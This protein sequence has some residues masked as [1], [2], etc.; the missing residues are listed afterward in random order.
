MS[1]GLKAMW[2]SSFAPG[3]L[4]LE[5]NQQQPETE[6]IPHLLQSCAYY[7]AY[8]LHLAND[9]HRFLSLAETSKQR[10]S[11]DLPSGRRP[12]QQAAETLA[13]EPRP[14]E[15]IPPLTTITPCIFVPIRDDMVKNFSKPARDRVERLR[16]ILQS[17]DY[18]R[19]GIKENL[20]YMIDREKQRLILKAAE[21]EE[22]EGT[23]N[24]QRGLDPREADLLILNMEAPVQPGRDYNIKNEQIPIRQAQVR[25]SL[26]I[27]E[28]VVE[29]LLDM[30]E[31]GARQLASYEV[32]VT[33]IKQRY[34]DILEKELETMQEAGMRPEEREAARA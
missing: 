19:E 15:T 26:P 11:S 5:N 13:K 18:Q 20:V 1:P 2:G 4:H 33:G 12:A 31:S 22:D 32:H 21:I 10:M 23:V 27:R 8:G 28:R 6:G 3:I 17:I 16:R 30:I 29:E 14:S 24:L 7:S 34:L 25:S 9:D